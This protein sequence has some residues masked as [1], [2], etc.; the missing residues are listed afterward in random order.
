LAEAEEHYRSAIALARKL[1]DRLHEAF[2]LERLGLMLDVTANMAQSREALEQAIQAYRDSGDNEGLRRSLARLSRVYRAS[3][4]PPEVGL[5]C[6]EPFLPSLLDGEASEGRGMLRVALARLYALTGRF[7]DAIA[8]AERAK[9]IAHALGDVHLEAEAEHWRSGAFVGLGQPEESLRVAEQALPL[10]ARGGDLWSE[11]FLL[12]DV[13]QAHLQ[14]GTMWQSQEAAARAVELAQHMGMPGPLTYALYLRGEIA[15]HLGDWG[16]ARADAERALALVRPL[17]TYWI[18]DA[19][20]MLLG[21]LC[22]AE[23]Q[24]ESG[25]RHVEEGMA[26]AERMGESFTSAGGSVAL[27]RA[28]IAEVELLSGRA[29]RVIEELELLLDELAGADR[30]QLTILPCL[31]W[32]Y[33]DAGDPDRAAGLLDEVLAH[34]QAQLYRLTLMEVLLVQARIAIRRQHWKAAHSTLECAISVAR[35]MR[36]PYAEAKALYLSGLLHTAQGEAE[37]ARGRLEAALAILHR[38]GE[39]QYGEH[40]ERALADLAQH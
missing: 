40:V 20:R 12:T 19:P 2:A 28:V 5:T 8:E 14:M 7:D 16:R 24:W 1:D 18:A 32:A 26:L 25:Q 13:T 37:S 35:A 39:R 11:C 17:G 10:A 33:L 9:E 4:M 27:G 21:R 3:G 36:S 38:L 23:G 31:A 34:P 22:L 29:H 6:L 15:F 30:G